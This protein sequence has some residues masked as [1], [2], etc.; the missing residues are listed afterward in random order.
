[1]LDL[2]DP[3]PQR[4]KCDGSTRRDFLKIGTLGLFGGI[5]LPQV[6]R[7]RANASEPSKPAKKTPSVV[8][9]FLDGGA[10]QFETFDPKMDAPKE[11]RCLFGSTKTPMAGIDFCSLLPKM[12]KLADQMAIVKSFTHKDGDHGGATH[13]VK[14]G[15]PWPPEFLGK[16]PVIPQQSPSIGSVV[17]RCKGPINQTT[18]VPTNV[19]I[20][21][22]HGGY[23]GDDA[24]WLG[25]AYAPFRVGL[26][27]SNNQML[28]NMGL[29]IAPE[30]LGDRRTLLSAFDTLDRELDQSGV[31]K[32]MDGFTQQAVNVLVGKAKE[33]FDLSREDEKTKERY[34]EGLGQELLLARR[35]CEAGSTFV[36]LNNGYWDHHDGIIPGCKKLC[37]P[38]DH[39]VDAFIQDVKERGLTND[40]LLVITCEF[41][42]TPRIGNYN[43]AK[44][45]ST[46][47]DHWAGLNPLAFM[48]GGLKMGQIIGESD[49]RGGY[50][51]SKAISPQ[52]FMATILQVLDIDQKVQFNHPSGR[53]ISMIED[54]KAIDELF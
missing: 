34:G 17:A 35:L 20:L 40:I 5:T 29:K 9:L 8:L 51:K 44:E 38:L 53:P 48:G 33:A 23:P 21:S 50:P 54:G 24:V 19:R 3:R 7:I 46:G 11:Y 4:R 25:Q 27:G 41:G 18:G 1:M 2:I 15:Y 45:S 12:A 10:S 47:R 6:L 42:R 13:W 30:R 26:K 14:T 39:A 43:N 36:T 52:D 31:M 28:N 16:A 32:G 22:N 49:D 37:P